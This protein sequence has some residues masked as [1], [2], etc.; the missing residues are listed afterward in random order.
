MELDF[1]IGIPLLFVGSSGVACVVFSGEDKV[2]KCE[3]SVR[4]R[5]LPKCYVRKCES[6]RMSSAK[7]GCGSVK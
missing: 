4:E 6:A 7:V 2:Y 3:C 1:G 5:E